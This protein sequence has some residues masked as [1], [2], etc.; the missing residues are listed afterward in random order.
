MRKRF[1]AGA[2]CPQCQT[3]DTLAVGREN[4]TETV[5]CVKCG[6]QQSRSDEPDMIA[7]RPADEIIGIFHPE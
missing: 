2:I 3:Q 7:G 4:Q 5:V 6:Y 1:I